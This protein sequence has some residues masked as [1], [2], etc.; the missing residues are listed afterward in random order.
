M[1]LLCV[2]IETKETK[3]KVRTTLYSIWQYH[4]KVLL[5]SVD[6]ILI[7][8]EQLIENYWAVLLRDIICF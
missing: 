7:M 6:E 3:L 5:K 8:C 4:M 1:K 2:T